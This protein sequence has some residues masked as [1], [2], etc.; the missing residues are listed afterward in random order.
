MSRLRLSG[1]T[2]SDGRRLS[3]RDI[4][5]ARV[6]DGYCSRF[7]SSQI[8]EV[9]HTLRE[10]LAV[11]LVVRRQD[12]GI[13]A[14]R[15]D[16]HRSSP[17]GHASHSD[18]LARVATFFRPKST[19]SSVHRLPKAVT[20]VAERVHYDLLLRRRSRAGGLGPM[21]GRGGGRNRITTRSA[22]AVARGA[23]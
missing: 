1:L 14:G 12:E 18:Q 5:N 9:P 6:N 21:Q 11:D 19:C 8:A 17:V 7:R 15:S 23:T 2:V 22:R 20:V 4:D 13:D 16:Y 3:G 10:E